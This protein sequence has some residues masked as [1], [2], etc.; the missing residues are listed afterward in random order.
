M[1]DFK[2]KSNLHQRITVF[3]W[4]LWQWYSAEAVF[5][6]VMDTV[7]AI[8]TFYIISLEHSGKNAS[9]ISLKMVGLNVYGKSR[10]QLR[11]RDLR[12]HEFE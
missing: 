1:S 12:Q 3:G 11:L 10:T 4:Y 7:A 9:A 6:M 2:F 5:L 8:L